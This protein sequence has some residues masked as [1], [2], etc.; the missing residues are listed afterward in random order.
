MK[1]TL[2]NYQQS[3]RKVRL[4]GNLIKGKSVT[5]A[6]NELTY[7]VKRSSK[8]MKDLLKSAVASAVTQTGAKVEDLVI[9]NVTVDKGMVMKRSMP[10]AFGR[11]SRINH[12]FSHVTITLGEKAVAK[13]KK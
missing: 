13:K 7:L 3:P 2:S 10:R 5:Q 9:K 4:V 6:D 8:P 12:R 11:A 1:A